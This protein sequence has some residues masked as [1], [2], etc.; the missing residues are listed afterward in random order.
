MPDINFTVSRKPVTIY[1]IVFTLQQYYNITAS[2]G[3]THVLTIGYF[4]KLIDLNSW[5]K[6][7]YNYKYKFKTY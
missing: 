7:N 2:S 1:F 4:H 6:T 5:L 3:F